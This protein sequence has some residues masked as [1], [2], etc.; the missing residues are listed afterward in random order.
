M[1]F[2]NLLS[3]GVLSVIMLAMA[4]CSKGGSEILDTIP[5]EA[6]VAAVIDVK[7]LC[8][9]CG[10]TLSADGFEADAAID[11]KIEGE[12]RENIAAVGRIH[13]SGAADLSATALF[14][15]ADKEVFC[16]FAISGF[17]AFRDACADR[18]TWANDAE[19]M[20]V[21]TI[22]PSSTVVASEK[23]VWISDLSV[24]KAPAAVKKL[25]GKATDNPLGALSGV[26]EWLRKGGLA[27]IVS[28]SG[29]APRS[30]HKEAQAALWNTGTL[31]SDENGLHLDVTMMTGDGERQSVPGLKEI[32]SA[33]LG[34]AG[35]DP[36]LAL[37]FGVGQGFDWSSIQK[38]VA[39]SGDFSTM[40]MFSTAMP[41]LNA[42]DGTVMIAA[43]P[44][45]PS[46][47]GAFDL[48]TWQYILMAHMPQNKVDEVLGTVRTMCF[49][50]GISPE[51]VSEGVLR[52]SQF[53]GEVY[54]GS[55]DGYLAVS[56]RPFSPNGQNSLAP[57][58]V[59]KEAAASLT[60]PSLAAYGPGL[61]S[62]GLEVRGGYEGDQAHVDVT[63][64]GAQGPVLLNLLKVL[65]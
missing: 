40:A 9:D 24:E 19:G 1:K 52:I 65:L 53:G 32:N 15:T 27:N 11:G 5:A 20:H 3:A 45:D 16:T 54:V 2:N 63:T 56:N 37:A 18:I 55:V 62:W 60:L 26:G 31:S 47:A 50:A 51:T 7:A 57:V 10:I 29:D 41:Y 35:N 48:A 44:F 4:S 13:E 30:T 25:L 61:P 21:G 49:S 12:L 23:Q 42:I 8:N 38:L 17:E 58:F 33:V 59:N 28:V 34:Y 14:M 46:D 22:P 36:R 6:P 43:Q 39:L 64:P